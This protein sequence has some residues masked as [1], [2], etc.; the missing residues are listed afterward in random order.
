MPDIYNPNIFSIYYQYQILKIVNEYVDNKKQ[1]NSQLAEYFIQ[2]LSENAISEFNKICV[3]PNDE[4]NFT[5]LQFCI[6]RIF[7]GINAD[8]DE[9]NNE[10]EKEMIK[11][12]VK[13]IKQQIMSPYIKKD[14]SKP[15]RPSYCEKLGAKT[16]LK[17][18]LEQYY[19]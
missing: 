11:D 5:N 7:N 17:L 3:N 9:I 16:I 19:Q 15:D 8:I 12:L 13:N 1:T 6:R 18:N 4:K 14:C 2:K 10:T